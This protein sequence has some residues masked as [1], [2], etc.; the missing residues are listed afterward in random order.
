ML[1]SIL[2]FLLCLLTF[3][4]YLL[5]KNKWI[6]NILR[7]FIIVAV[8]QW[9]YLPIILTMF[10]ANA[11]LEINDNEIKDVFVLMIKELLFLEIILFLFIITE[12]K[13]RVKFSSLK[14]IENPVNFENIFFVISTIFIGIQI[15]YIFLYKMDYTINNDAQETQGGF[16]QLIS[17]FVNFFVSYF[18]VYYIFAQ[19]TKFKNY[20]V[21]FIISIY[22]FT[23]I[24]TGSRIYFLGFLFLLII[25]LVK[26]KTVM[27]K[28]RK[29]TSLIIALAVSLIMLPIL[30]STRVG[31][32]SGS[33]SISE[34]IKLVPEQLNIKLNSFS[35][36]EVLLKYDGAGFAGFNPYI[37][38]IMKFVPRF[39]WSNKPTATSFNSDV[40]GIP[41]RRI[42]YLQG[43]K[44]DSYNVGVSAFA[45]SS[46]QMGY[47][48]VILAIIVN[49]LFLKYVSRCLNNKSLIIK[50]IGFM[51]IGFPQLVMI[52][53]YGDNIIQNIELSIIL[54]IILISFKVLVF[55]K[56]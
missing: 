55:K 19:K 45:V 28:I 43:V 25:S 37:G 14:L 30:A 9:Y 20:F 1:I 11:V 51:L 42:P 6:N 39:V 34:S 35:Y 8:I 24:L 12:N 50:S 29:S 56:K 46:W 17:V 47:F 41:A 10:G 48:T 27:A 54:I 3:E 21:I 44:N 32:S 18:W 5:N 36:S 53:T 4:L 2:I 49:F 31:D 16:F 40:N 38:S 26:T 7:L 13:Y 33:S 23:M 15:I 22:S 52:P